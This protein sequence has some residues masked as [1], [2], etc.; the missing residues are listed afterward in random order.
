MNLNEERIV[1]IA[2]FTHPSAAQILVTILQSEGIN[3][4][5]RNAFS[6]QILGGYADIGGSRLEVLESD[7]ARAIE[8]AQDSGYGK[9]LI[10]H[11][12]GH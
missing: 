12:D 9:Y 3:C 6:S 1:E 10:R 2:R 4:Y 5:L 7:S 11:D 8:I